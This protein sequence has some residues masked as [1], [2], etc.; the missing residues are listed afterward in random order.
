MFGTD[1]LKNAVH[2]SSD[3]EHAN[4]TI[5]LIFGSEFAPEESMRATL[6]T[7]SLALKVNRGNFQYS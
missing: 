6:L 5:E 2:G 3:Q 7:P 4:R 1:Q